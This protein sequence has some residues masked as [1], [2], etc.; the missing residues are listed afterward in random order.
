MLVRAMRWATLERRA[1]GE[2][3]G[4]FMAAV[5]LLLPTLHAQAATIRV[6]EDQPTIQAAIDQVLSGRAGDTVIL[7]APGTYTVNVNTP[8]YYSFTLRGSSEPGATVIR[9]GP[10]GPALRFQSGW[11]ST[12]S[13]EQI[14]FSAGE[15]SMPYE[16]IVSGV[17]NTFIRHCRFDT[18]ATLGSVSASVVSCSPMADGC[19]HISDCDFQSNAEYRVRWMRGVTIENSLNSQI[20]IERSRFK[21]FAGHIGSAV[22]I[23]A[24]A[25]PAKILDCVF[26]RNSGSSGTAISV[27][28]ACKVINC[29][30]VDNVTTHDAVIHHGGGQGNLLVQNSI[31][32]RNTG[33]PIQIW[34]NW[35]IVA[36][37]IERSYVQGTIL[38]GVEY[39]PGNISAE[40]IFVDPDNGDYRLR[41]D[42]PGIDAG[43][44]TGREIDQYLDVELNRRFVDRLSTPDTG[45]LAP[46]LGQSARA[47]VDLGAY[48]Y[49]GTDPTCSADVDGTG[50]VTSED[51]F[52]YLDQWFAQMGTACP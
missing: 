48:E 18:P 24:R 6:P 9:H 37:K 52:T 3:M 44:N 8:V 33:S 34:G 28:G 49:Q 50:S 26:E 11:S 41:A 31:F 4:L 47:V 12:I 45:V 5:W 42:S 29:T 25:V 20:V 51:L 35:G 7:L 46:G 39:G 16:A 13:I 21:G 30:F 2:A 32:W 43:N 22:R 10:S 19:V 14:T 15:G 38:G 17:K 40:P 27:D 1:R 36:I 23:V